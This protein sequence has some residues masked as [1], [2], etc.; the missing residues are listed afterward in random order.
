MAHPQGRQGGGGGSAFTE[1]SAV[2]GRGRGE[3]PWPT[4]ML[5]R[6]VGKGP[7]SLNCLQCGAEAGVCAPMAHPQE[8]QGGGGGSAFTELSSVRGRGRGVSTLDP[9]GRQGGGG[10]SAFT[11]LSAV[12][13]RGWGVSTHGPPA[14]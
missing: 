1:L 9:Q 13:G 2:R 5:G 14:R 3:H 7:P 4:R 11:E 10:G 6:E 12:R 8:R